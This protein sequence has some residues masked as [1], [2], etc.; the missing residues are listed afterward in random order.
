MKGKEVSF[1]R[2]EEGLM[3]RVERRQTT[4]LAREGMDLSKYGYTRGGK[5]G[6]MIRWNEGEQ[7]R[8]RVSDVYHR[9]HPEAT[10]YYRG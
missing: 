4:V 10:F 6:N 7:A 2:W 8:K 3:E 1:I 5:K 9:K